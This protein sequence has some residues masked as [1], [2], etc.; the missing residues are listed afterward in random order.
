[1]STYDYSSVTDAND[2]RKLA[3]TRALNEGLA[4]IPSL[5]G[6]D[7]HTMLDAVLAEAANGRAPF[8][9]AQRAQG[10]HWVTDPTYGAD[11]TGVS[12]SRAAFATV[13]ALGE[14]GVVPPGTY[15]IAS[16]VTLTGH[17]T[18][19]PGAVLQ[20]DAGATVTFDAPSKPGRKYAYPAAWT[21]PS[22]DVYRRAD[23][24]WMLKDA[25]DRAF[26]QTYGVKS[27]TAGAA[28][29]KVYWVSP[30]G[31][32][33]TGLSPATALH[34]L[35]A[36]LA[37]AD[38]LTIMVEGGYVYQGFPSATGIAKSVNIIGYGTERAV[39]FYY[40]RA[41]TFSVNATYSNVYQI[42]DTSQMERPSSA[43]VKDRHGMPVSY[44][45]VSSVQEVSETPFSYYRDNLTMYVHASSAPV[46]GTDIYCT[47][48]SWYNSILVT[49]NNNANVTVYLENLIWPCGVRAL[50]TTGGNI[51]ALNC[52]A[53]G[54]QDLNGTWLMSGVATVL[55]RC[56]AAYGR[57]DGFNY[58]DG[59]QIEYDCLAYA[60]G[61]S[62]GS[63][64]GSTSHGTANT[65]RIGGVYESAGQ[66]SILDVGTG[67]TLNLGCHAGS[68]GASHSFGT[69]NTRTMWCID[70]RPSGITTG[71]HFDN[72]GTAT[73]YVEGDLRGLTF[74][75]AGPV[76][77]TQAE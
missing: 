74:G 50:S 15:R 6:A 42:T 5:Q 63:T 10:V 18:F 2:R 64:Q 59:T 1:M 12:D 75:G 58:T 67:Q 9:A 37:K 73:L 33:T 70:C 19:Q 68:R 41:P 48:E 57:V 26:R 24:V 55:N 22:P 36:A 47:L 77:A 13:D 29:N 28:G 30:N 39:I 21:G 11:S 71:R 62:G 51:H 61:D 60:N 23:G 31:D 76:V 45:Q 49:A 72:A 43:I 3:E 8:F 32:N 65:L 4:L 16:S 14:E 27:T 34:S 20:P 54:M 7:K 40:G 52:G 69:N 25:E 44:T 53:V 66:N 38:V 35:P 17:W 46:I 56:I